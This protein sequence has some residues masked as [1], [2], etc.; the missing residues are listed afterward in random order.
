MIVVAQE[1]IRTVAVQ[2]RM[3][4]ESEIEIE[5]KTVERKIGDEW[6]QICGSVSLE[7]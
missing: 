6:L 1:G 4:F 5:V 7:V 2:C 3:Y